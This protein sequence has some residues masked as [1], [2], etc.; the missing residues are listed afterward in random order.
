MLGGWDFDQVLV[1][2][3]GFFLVDAIHMTVYANNMWW[4]PIFVNRGD[5]DYYLV[6]PVSSL[7]FLSLRDFAANSFL[8]LLVAAGIVGWALAS[9]PGELGAGR[10]AVFLLL[11]V[12]GAFLYYLIHICFLIPVFWLH[13]ARGLGELFFAVEK[14]MER[15][16][17]IFHGYVRRILV[18]VLP[19]SLIASVPAEALFEGLSGEVLLHVTTVTGAGVLFL[20]MFWRRALRAYSSASS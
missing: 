16:E 14:F 5:L 3:S 1:F 19:F 20:V 18:T 6:R 4:L 10:V 11:I 8:N 2:I 13:S 12:N 9:Y 15:P 7:F 17:R